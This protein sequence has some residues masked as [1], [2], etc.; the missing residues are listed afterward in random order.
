MGERGLVSRGQ[1]YLMQ[2]GKKIENQIE[3]IGHIE[4]CKCGKRM[5][6]RKHKAITQ[7]QKRKAYYFS[8]WDYCPKHKGGCGHL[9]NYD[10]FRVNNELGHYLEESERQNEHFKFI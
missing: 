1:N 5:E 6:R 10:K 4:I 7:K 9:Q 8:E 2:Q 3:V